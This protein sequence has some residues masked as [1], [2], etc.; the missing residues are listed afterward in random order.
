VPVPSARVTFSL[1]SGAEGR[2]TNRGGNRAVV[3]MNGGTAA[4]HPGTWS[5]SL[6][7]LV[8]RLARRRPELGFLEV[9][10]R[11]KS[12]RRLELCVEDA[13]AAIAAARAAG[14]GEVA[15]IGFSMGGAVAVHVAADPAVSTVI[16]LAPWLYPELDLA[17]LEGRRFAVVHGSLD[18]A[19]PGVPGVRPELS[20]HGYDRARALGIDAV[21]TVIPG[22]LHPIALRAP[23]GEPVRMPRAERWE[24]LVDAELGRFCA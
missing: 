11:I 10:Y 9:R 4:E 12:W 1:E 16:A 17:P 24:E 21:R 7:W 6:E 18:R 19:L 5:A 22:A 15:L 3:C 23:W 20:L 13:G 2:W 8:G 14:A